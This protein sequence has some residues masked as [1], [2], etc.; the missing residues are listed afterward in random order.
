MNI[1]ISLV[2]L[3]VL[4][5]LMYMLGKKSKSKIIKL[6]SA[7]IE[8]EQKEIQGAERLDH[9]KNSGLCLWRYDNNVLYIQSPNFSSTTVSFLYYPKLHQSVFIGLRHTVAQEF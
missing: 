8:D 4:P 5:C 1:S 7:P 3:I 2:L 6:N 9:S